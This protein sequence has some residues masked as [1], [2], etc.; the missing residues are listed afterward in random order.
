M[1]K[2]LVLFIL[3]TIHIGFA[4]KPAL[5][6]VIQKPV[7][8]KAPAKTQTISMEYNEDIL[9]FAKTDIIPF[10]ENLAKIDRYPI[11]TQ[12]IGFLNASPAEIALKQKDSIKFNN[13]GERNLYKILIQFAPEMRKE[14]TVA[15]LDKKTKQFNTPKTKV[16]T[17]SM[18]Y[19]TE[20]L[21]FSKA[22]L[23]ALLN[24]KSQ[25]DRVNIYNPMIAYLNAA[26]KPVLFTYSDT[27]KLADPAEKNIHKIILEVAPQLLAEGKAADKVKKTGAFNK[28]VFVNPCENSKEKKLITEK[29]GRVILSCE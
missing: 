8:L 20:T 14:G 3:F 7:L 6:A 29:K 26:D 4:Q 10:V 21:Y 24:K 5:K 22:D 19:S 11:Y 1:K 23:T 28:Q 2:L 18:E 27:A 12:M 25:S 17:I 15:I 9:Y 16:Q 13:M